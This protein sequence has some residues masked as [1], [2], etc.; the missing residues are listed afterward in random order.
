MSGGLKTLSLMINF[1]LEL[2][3]THKKFRRDVGKVTGK[4]SLKML[5]ACPIPHSAK[6]AHRNLL[7]KYF[8]VRI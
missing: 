5:Y 6:I 2:D 1:L 3:Y 7:P 4:L 8:L